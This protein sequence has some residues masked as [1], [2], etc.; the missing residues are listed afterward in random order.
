MPS[1]SNFLIT[2]SQCGKTRNSPSPKKYYVKWTLLKISWKQRFYWRSY[3]EIASL[4]KPL[5]SRNFVKEVRENFGSFH[6]TMWKT[7]NSISPKNISSNRL[8]SKILGCRDPRYKH[9]NSSITIMFVEC[10]YQS[11][12]EFLTN[13][14][15]FVVKKWFSCLRR[16]FVLKKWF[17][18]WRNDFLTE[19][20][21]KFSKS[22]L[23][24]MMKVTNIYKHEKSILVLNLFS[25]RYFHEIFS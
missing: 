1:S 12:N 2:G 17:S 4:V 20:M 10:F 25:N 9:E 15:I 24:K 19:E 22:P 8:F 7:R 5:L 11:W 14:I 3:F 18:Y 21:H 6:I 23:K 16:I 13:E